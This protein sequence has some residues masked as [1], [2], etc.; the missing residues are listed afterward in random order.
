M[1]NFAHRGASSRYPEN[2]ML[3]LREAIS[4]GCD[5]IELD[6]HKSKDNMVVVIHDENIKRTFKGRGLI[7]NYTL[8]EL[9][10][11]K[12]RKRGF[13]DNE[14]CLIPTLDEVL[15]LIMDK[16]IYLNIE[17]KTDVIHYKNIEEDVIN[18]VKKY[19]L[20][21]R[22]I[23]SSFNHRSLKICK[24]IDSDIQVGALYSREIKRVIDYAKT[25]QLDAIHPK[26]SL[27]SKELIDE[28]HNNGIKVNVYTVNKVNEMKKLINYNV[29]GIFTDYTDVLKE[30]K[31]EMISA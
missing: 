14:Q 22:V 26:L 1:I 15:Q 11:F 30:V 19:N 25:L 28:A 6:V 17:L 24:S 3:A 21:K 10:K 8:D 23:I 31:E 4:L 13:E 16:N 5:G 7:K 29:D 12:C 20:K 9:K 2:T 27:I 18:L